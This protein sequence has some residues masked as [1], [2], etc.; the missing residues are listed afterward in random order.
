MTARSWRS[1]L[2]GLPA[3]VVDVAMAVALTAAVTIAIGVAPEQGRPPGP[4]AFTLGPAIGGLALFRRR[5][6]LAVLVISGR[7]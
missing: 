3:P 6:P 2:Q 7:H 5:W 1:R 4:A